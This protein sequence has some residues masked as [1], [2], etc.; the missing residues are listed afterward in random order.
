M[1]YFEKSI[2]ETSTIEHEAL[3]LSQNSNHPSIARFVGI[4]TNSFIN[5][6]ILATEYCSEGTLIDFVNKNLVLLKR[7]NLYL[8]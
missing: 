1:K 3:F 5:H 2:L 7:L 8:E 4:A 6:F